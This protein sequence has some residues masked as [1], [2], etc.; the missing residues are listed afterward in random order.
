MIEEYAE[1]LDANDSR[2][3]NA[4][5]EKT[6]ELEKLFENFINSSGNHFHEIEKRIDD[7]IELSNR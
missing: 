1:N 3:Q 7:R 4:M 2:I 6:E 5:N